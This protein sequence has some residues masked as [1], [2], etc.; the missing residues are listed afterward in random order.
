MAQYDGSIRIDTQINTKN[1]NAQLMSLESRIVKM[2]DK[3]SALRSRMDALKDAE[4]STQE[5]KDIETD[6]AK[7]ER[8]LDKLLEKQAQMQQDGRDNGSA[9][10]TINQRIQAQRDYVELAREE[11][12]ELVD[13]GRAFT[14]GSNT[15][16]YSNLGQQLEYLENDYSTLIQRRNEFMQRHNIQAGGYERLQVAL[17]ELKNS[18]LLVMHPI[19]A[20]KS[21]FSSA[22][23]DMKQRIAGIAASIINGIAHP[24]QAMKNIAGTAVKGTSKFLSGMASIAKKVGKAIGSVA[25]IL[26]KATSSMFSF[27]KSTK[28]SNNMLQ[29]GF[30]NILKYGLGIRSFY[31]LINKFRTGAKE[32]FGNLAQYSEPVNTALSSLKSSLLQLKNSLATAF[33]PILTVAAPALTALIDMASRAATAIGMLIAALTGQKTFVKAKKVQQGYADSLKGTSKAAK[34]ANKQLSSLDKLNNLTSNDS[35]DGG[36]DSGG[37]AGAGDMFETVDIPS[38][39]GNFAD[40]IKKAWEEADFTENRRANWNEIKRGP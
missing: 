14:L 20:M 9:W 11:M 34:D 5:Y 22:M 36:G 7:A 23:E 18:M 21:S 3:I 26:K 13:T 17:Q 30:K 16:E 27:G 6:I 35:G 40:M 38:Q 10:D 4:I 2:A 28:S 25:S 24:F 39:I 1:A 37:G 32:G 33:A 12:Q 29:S 15:Q 19:E 31:A 8:V